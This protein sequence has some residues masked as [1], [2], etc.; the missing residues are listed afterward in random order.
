MPV[1]E[2]LLGLLG[3][4][5]KSPYQPSWVVRSPGVFIPRV[6]FVALCYSIVKM[7]KEVLIT[8]MAYL[9]ILMGN[10]ILFSWNKEGLIKFM[11]PLLT[12]VFY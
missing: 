4:D 10:E 5:Q 3:Q 1:P 6:L 8:R 7:L 11:I 2:K 9:I 12:S